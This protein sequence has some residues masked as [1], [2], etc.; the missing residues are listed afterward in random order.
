MK[1]LFF[2]IFIFFLFIDC[3]NN[4]KLYVL[5]LIDCD[6]ITVPADVRFKDQTVGTIDKILKI[7]ENE[8]CIIVNMQL[9]NQFTLNDS[10]KMYYIPVII[11]HPY[12][13]IKYK[14]SEELSKKRIKNDTILVEKWKYEF[15][16]K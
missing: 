2:G 3:K 9:E 4:Q 16:N 10:M 12:L 11:G 13:V 5:K 7:N 8:P 15:D 14:T 1:N 6:F